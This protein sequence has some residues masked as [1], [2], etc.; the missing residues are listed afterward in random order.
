MQLRGVESTP[1]PQMRDLDGWSKLGYKK[2]S[3]KKK[4]SKNALILRL[5][6]VGSHPRKACTGDSQK[7]KPFD[8]IYHSFWVIC[9]QKIKK[10]IGFLK[11]GLLCELN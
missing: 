11:H 8:P 10:P 7:W 1:K 6:G 2:N 5:G 9:D 3:N 4:N